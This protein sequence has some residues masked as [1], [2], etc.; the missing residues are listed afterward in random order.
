MVRPGRDCGVDSDPADGR[1]PR[2]TA[3]AQK[4][5]EEQIKALQHPAENLEDRSFSERCITRGSPQIR[6]GYQ[7][8]DQIVQTPTAVMIMAEMFHDVRVIILD[9]RPHLPAAI[10]EW[11]GDSRGHWEGNTMV[12]DTTNCRSRAFQS[13]SSEKLHITERLTR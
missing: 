7:S 1:R 3:Q 12:V 8:Y 9:N 4:L 11:L 13:I 10:Q 6:A 2:L 5:Q